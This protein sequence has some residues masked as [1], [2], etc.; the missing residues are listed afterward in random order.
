MNKR[1]LI[2]DDHEVVLLGT[3]IALQT[4][5]GDLIIDTAMDYTDGINKIS[6]EKI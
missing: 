1:I 6:N 5:M 2:V 4:K 3:K